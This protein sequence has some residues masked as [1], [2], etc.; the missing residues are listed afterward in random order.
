MIS[1]KKKTKLHSHNFL[2][3]PFKNHNP[4]EIKNIHTRILSMRSANEN[5]IE[6][7]NINFKI[8]KVVDEPKVTFSF[9]CAF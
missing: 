9:L 3:R 5:K 6:Q 2:Q 8:L 7:I 1:F 4:K